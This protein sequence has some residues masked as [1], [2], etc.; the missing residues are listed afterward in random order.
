MTSTVRISEVR[1]CTELSNGKV[2]PAEF[3]GSIA[4]VGTGPDPA[5]VVSEEWLRGVLWALEVD[6]PPL[7]IGFGG[8]CDPS[9]SGTPFVKLDNWLDADRVTRVIADAITSEQ[10]QGE[11]RV[12]IE[13][14]NDLC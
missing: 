13:P 11:V 14:P 9:G 5:R 2:Y 6:R 7:A 1:D 8:L 3:T 12:L 10:L 4:I